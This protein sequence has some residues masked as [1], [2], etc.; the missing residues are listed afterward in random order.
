MIF[1]ECHQLWVKKEFSTQNE[2]VHSHGQELQKITATHFFW[3]TLVIITRIF[4]HKLLIKF[5]NLDNW[6]F[7]N[8]PDGDSIALLSLDPYRFNLCYLKYWFVFF[9]AKVYLVSY[10][11]VS[12]M[13][14]WYLIFEQKPKKL[15]KITDKHYAKDVPYRMHCLTSSFFKWQS[16][17]WNFRGG[18]NYFRLSRCMLLDWRFRDNVIGCFFFNK[19]KEMTKQLWN[20]EVL[21]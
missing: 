9:N 12:G 8:I 15:V 2:R 14:W 7:S 13:S 19:T 16:Q 11:S 3:R 6:L 21:T 17:E 18:M 1:N 5:W 4:G 10:I 20:K